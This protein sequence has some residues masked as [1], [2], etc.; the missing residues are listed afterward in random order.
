MKS[1]IYD[2]ISKRVEV[3][4]VFSK[5]KTKQF[6]FTLIITILQLLGPV[7]TQICE[8][9][10]PKPAPDPTPAQIRKAAI[11]EAKQVKSGKKPNAKHVRKAMQ[12]GCETKEEA[13]VLLAALYDDLAHVATD[14]EIRSELKAVNAFLSAS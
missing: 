4:A 1:G 11:K 14:A 10:K 7:I 2:R 5:R 13:H 9:F 8:L 3:V 6:S 12:N